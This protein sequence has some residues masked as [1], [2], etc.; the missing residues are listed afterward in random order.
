MSI[1]LYTSPEQ[2]TPGKFIVE[3]PYGK[4]A[5]CGIRGLVIK[6]TPKSVMA[7]R[8]YGDEPLPAFGESDPRRPVRSSL[9]D[10]A[11]VC[12]SEEEARAL[13]R[14]SDELQKAL[15]REVEELAAKHSAAKRSVIHRLVTP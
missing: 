9:S 3:H 8:S 1:A 12:D 6:V 7:I 5:V 11:F 2:L 15:T 13:Q 4:N 14:A 10:V